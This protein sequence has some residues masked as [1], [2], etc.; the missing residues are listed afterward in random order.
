MHQPHQCENDNHTHQNPETIS[1]YESARV[2]L[3]VEE[4]VGVETLRGFCEVCEGDVEGKEEDEE[5]EMKGMRG[6][7]CWEDGFEEREKRWECVLGDLWE[8]SIDLR[9]KGKGSG[10]MYVSKKISY[11]RPRLECQRKP[12][13]LIDKTPINNHDNPREC[14]HRRVEDTMQH[15]HYPGTLIENHGTPL[16]RVEES[17]D[18]RDEEVERITPETQPGEEAEWAT[19]V[20]VV[21]M[22]AV[23]AKDEE[24]G[25]EGVEGD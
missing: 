3:R 21:A 20:L 4:A 5:R 19:C 25:H 17:M 23:P 12:R 1:R 16:R 22:C 10:S 24:D 6:K 15:P 14:R 2:R 9:T 7:G 8:G 18:T 11:I 13:V